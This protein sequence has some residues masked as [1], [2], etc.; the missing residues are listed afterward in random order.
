MEITLEWW[1]FLLW[2]PSAFN[3]IFTF[4][5]SARSHW[6]NVTRTIFVPGM[7]VM[8][9]VLHEHPDTLCIIIGINALLQTAKM[10]Y[11]GTFDN[12]I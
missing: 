4:L 10:V 3:F 8:H 7:G 11:T 1:F 5:A 9:M 6:M 2:L 12:R